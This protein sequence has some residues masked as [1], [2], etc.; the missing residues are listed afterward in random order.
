LCQLCPGWPSARSGPR[1]GGDGQLHW[2]GAGR[3]PWLFDPHKWLTVTVKVEPHPDW[4]QT[5]AIPFAPT[6]ERPRPLRI[7]TYGSA[8]ILAVMAKHLIDVDEDALS[9]AQAEL[10]TTTIKDTV[11]RALQN[12]TASRQQQLAAAMEVLARA[13]LDDR[14]EAWR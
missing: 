3:L 12:A 11:N 8:Y 13:D 1:S 9:A 2:D 5:S 14:S 6:N 7:Y 4:E 10:G